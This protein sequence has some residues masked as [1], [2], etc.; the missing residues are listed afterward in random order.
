MSKIPKVTHTQIFI[1]NEF[2]N[3]LSGKTFPTIN[4]S[5][6]EVITQIQEGDKADIDLAVKAA[7]NAFKL[8]STWR[9][10]DASKRGQL[11]HKLADLIERDQHYLAVSHIHPVD[12]LL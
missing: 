12:C 7:R 5:T 4:P 11:L 10:L 8:G 2:R 6:G 3:S 9:T 1:N